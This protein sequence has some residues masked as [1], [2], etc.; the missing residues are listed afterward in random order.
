MLARTG[1]LVGEEAPSEVRDDLFIEYATGSKPFVKWV[2]GKGQ[3]LPQLRRYYPKELGLG[4]VKT[5]IEPFVGGG[6]VFFDI[7]NHFPIRSAILIDANA[8]L[9]NTY[10]VIQSKTDA[11]LDRLMQFQNQYSS[12]KNPEHFFYQKRDAYNAAKQKPSKSLSV[13]L[14]ALFIFLNKTCYNGL[15]R[16]NSKGLFNT[17]FGKY[18]NPTICNEANIMS[19]KRSLEIAEIICGD[20]SQAYTAVDS[21]TFVYLDPPYRPISK[22]AS[23]AAYTASGFNDTE[24][25]R[26]ASLYRDLDE[27]KG[28]FLMLSNSSV[29]NDDLL[30]KWYAGF[31]LHT[32]Y[33]ARMINSDGNKRGQVAELVVTNYGEGTTA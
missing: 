16:V 4:I 21:N 29:A 30:A 11:L 20:F 15:Y 22:T 14:A 19:V 3:L 10:L 24:Q 7:V 6:A 9:V 31:H 8:D 1:Y 13:E 26:L 5:Y 33:A 2:G 32:V 25:Y 28:A 27:N 18:A 12:S 17:P 23:F